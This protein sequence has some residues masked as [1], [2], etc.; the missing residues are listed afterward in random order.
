MD[1]DSHWRDLELIGVPPRAVYIRFIRW[2]TD[3]LWTCVLE[4]LEDQPLLQ[5]KLR[6]KVL[7]YLQAH[8][9]RETR[10]VL[11]R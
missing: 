3:D 4:Q 6:A 9:R 10:P 2:A 5:A 11:A 1:S 7:H 8:E